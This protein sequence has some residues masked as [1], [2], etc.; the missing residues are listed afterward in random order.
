MLEIGINRQAV[1]INETLHAIQS[2]HIYLYIVA[3]WKY[4]S[5]TDYLFDS[6]VL[7]VDIIMEM[8]NAKYT[9]VIGYTVYWCQ[10]YKV[11]DTVKIHVLK[12]STAQYC[13]EILYA[14][15]LENY[16]VCSFN[17]FMLK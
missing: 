13:M 9:I 17:L 7:W 2:S 10:T 11:F 14:Y 4:N 5:E 6:K 15:I 1:H 12:G 8:W 3:V 16:T